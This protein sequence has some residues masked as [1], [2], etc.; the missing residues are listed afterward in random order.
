MRAIAASL[1]LTFF[2]SSFSSAAPKVRWP[3]DVVEWAKLEEARETAAKE[4]K[5]CA[6]IFV[7]VDWGEDISEGVVRS[8][9]ATNDA[10]GGLKSF[11]LIVKG[12][13]LAVG[14]ARQGKEDAAP[15]ALLEGL[16]KAGNTYPLVVVLGPELKTVL[17]ATSGRQINTEGRK[18]FREAKKKFRDLMETREEKE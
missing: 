14:Q 5:A 1:I 6:F 18:V 15:K 2:A 10:I 11:C 7:P 4:E 9:E 16:N 3:R 13:F 17:G 8:I 12:D